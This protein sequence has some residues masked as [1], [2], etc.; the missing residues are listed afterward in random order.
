[1][2]FS[3]IRVDPK[4][5]SFVYLLG[6]SQY[7]SENGGLT[8]DS[9]FGNAVHADGHAIWIDPRDGRHIIVGVD[10]GV[11]VT[12][13]RG[14]NWDHLN[15][16]ALG[17]FYHVAIGQTYPYYLYGGLQDN[18]TWVV[19]RKRSVPL[20]PS[21][22]IGYRSVVATASAVQSIPKIPTWFTSKAR[23]ERLAVAI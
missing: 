18:G 6:V 21:M 4:D 19:R 1:M 15:T 11:Y 3:V 22:R 23:M 10:G 8:F 9:S 12:Y 20:A 7:K 13:D 17:Q 5:A 2:Y 16:L 14:K